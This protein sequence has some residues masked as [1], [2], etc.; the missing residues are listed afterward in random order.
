MMGM[1]DEE[2]DVVMDPSQKQNKVIDEREDEDE[3]MEQ[4]DINLDEEE[5]EEN[6]V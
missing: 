6:G 3:L 4:Y 2:E 5:E 1:A